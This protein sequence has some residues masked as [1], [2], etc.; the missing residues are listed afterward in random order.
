MRAQPVTQCRVLELGCAAGGNLIPMAYAFP[1]SSFVGTD[2]SIRQISEG[3]KQIEELGLPN[4]ELKHLDIRDVG[5]DFGSFHYIICHGVYSW[6][7]EAV[8][9]KI[10]EICSKR[11]AANGVAY[12]SYN[13]YPGWHMRGMIRDM[14][15][16]HSKHFSDAMVKVK[17]SRNL[18]E[19]L[20]RSV[21]KEGSPYTLLLK[22]ELE[23]LRRSKDSYLFHEHLEECNDPVYFFEFAER[24]A[25]KGLKYLGEADLSVMLP[26]NYPPEVENVLRMMS[27]DNIHVEQY[28]DFLRNRTFRQTLL[29]HQTVALNYSLRAERLASFYVSS[30]A[31]PVHREVSLTSK[32]AEPF[33]GADEVVLNAREPL[34]KAAMLY[35]SEIWPRAVSFES[36]RDT[37]RSR[38][39]AVSPDEKA[40]TQRDTQILGECL[41]TCYTSASTSLVQLHTHPPEFVTEL[42]ERPVGSA[43]ARLQAKTKTRVTNLRHETVLLGDLD[44]EVLERLDGQ[45]DR[46]ALLRAL[47]EA[48]RQGT[49]S[50][51]REGVPVADAE[52]VQGVLKDGLNDALHR[53]AANALLIG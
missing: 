2:L 45:H 46:A 32:E 1:Q 40:T 5:D 10:L 4:I 37:A 39:N 6:V 24:A 50:I 25:A 12:V 29:C 20:T 3:R 47:T 41:L 48:V 42:S 8:Q 11:L 43:L 9:D 14:M 31:K 21:K 51:E 33:K 38:L 36:L 15:R 49:L 22:S 18:L 30:P 13:T 53:L 44:R 27:P 34:A 17:Q 7:P 16:Y 19:F 35:L 52:K 26:E 23:S 28:M